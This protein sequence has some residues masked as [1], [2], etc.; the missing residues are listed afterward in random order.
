VAQLAAH[1]L[2]QAN[3]E[4]KQKLSFAAETNAALERHPWPG[5]VRELKNL[6]ERLA[7]LKSA[8]AIGMAD[9]PES[10]RTPRLPAPEPR[11]ALPASG[12]DLHTAL[13]ELED[14]LITDA[15]QLSGGNKSHAASMLGL[16][17]TTLIE[18]LRRRGKPP[19]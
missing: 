12:I 2:A 16:K 1:F 17:R 10:I 6:V 14:R 8:G 3:A 5:N 19:Q 18:K 9:L 11:A 4:R 15:L 13:A 7:V